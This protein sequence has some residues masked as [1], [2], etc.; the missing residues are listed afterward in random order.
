[1]N[2]KDFDKL[3]LW[4]TERLA[5]C[6]GG[7]IA[8]A[9]VW[10]C[11]I[12]WGW[13]KDDINEPESKRKEY[14]KSGILE[15]I[16]AALPPLSKDYDFIKINRY[17]FNQQFAKLYAALHGYSVENYLQELP[18]FDRN[19]VFK[20]N[21]YPIAFRYDRDSLWKEYG[22]NHTFPTF[23]DKE[24]YREWCRQNR[25]PYFNSLVKQYRPEIIICT[26]L[27]YHKDFYRAFGDGELEEFLQSESTIREKDGVNSKPRT[28]YHSQLANGTHLFVIPFLVSRHG[29]NSHYLLEQM[30]KIIR[31]KRSLTRTVVAA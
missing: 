28:F 17:R 19:D 14:Y 4:A 21:L 2:D 1:M 9:R 29:L 7:N 18:N 12:E 11:G 10:L 31:D 25:F 26:G 23:P 30:G 20:M 15:E 13:R 8:R 22:L 3:R 16:E 24:S 6:D 5:G 27:G